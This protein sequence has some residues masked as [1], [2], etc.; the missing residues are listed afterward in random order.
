V[1]IVRKLGFRKRWKAWLIGGVAAIVVLAVGG[2]F[3]YI[4]FLNGN[5]PAALK[6][7]ASK[8]TSSSSSSTPVSNNVNGTWKI[9][10]GSQTGYRVHEVL[11]G[12][13]TTAVGRT[14]SITGSIV[15]SGTNVTKGSFSVDMTTVTSNK[16]QRDKQFQGRIMQTSTY[17]K[18]T[19]TLTKPITFGSVPAAGKTISATATGDLTLH[20]T[21]KSV[22][23]TVQALRSG[24]IIEVQG[25]IPVAFSD[26]KISSPSLSGFVTV[27]N[28]GTLE[29]L[30]HL[31]R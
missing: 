29:F 8:A 9:G 21:T 13:S 24:N 20:G 14:G 26:Y 15:I 6:L 22:T 5:E 4:H 27:D 28:H 23:F 31:G 30:L 19:F 2:P 10:S 16:S 3:V 12:Q 25:S 17:P 11:I 18:A 7:D 1:G